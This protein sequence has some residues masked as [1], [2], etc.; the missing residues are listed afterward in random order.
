VGIGRP[1][2]VDANAAGEELLR[3][4]NR[5]LAAGARDLLPWGCLCLGGNGHRHA[6][7]QRCGVWQVLLLHEVSFLE[8]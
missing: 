8:V 1:H 3:A 5:G 4:S 7:D 2:R 6:C